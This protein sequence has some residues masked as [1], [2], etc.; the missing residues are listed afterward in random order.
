MTQGRFEEAASEIEPKLEE[1]EAFDQNL[2]RY[3]RALLI[4]GLPERL[5]H[6]IRTFEDRVLA[7]KDAAGLAAAVLRIHGQTDD[8]EKFEIAFVKQRGR[9]QELMRV[10]EQVARMSGKRDAHMK[11]LFDLARVA[12]DNRPRA[13]L[14][15]T[16]LC[17]QYL[18]HDRAESAR[19]LVDAND[20]YGQMTLANL[21]AVKGDRSAVLDCVN[22]W[23]S[24][25]NTAPEAAN[26]IEGLWVS[27]GLPEL[28]DSMRAA[29][30]KW[31]D[32]P[33]VMGSA[34][35]YRF[36]DFERQS[37]GVDQANVNFRI[38]A[39]NHLNVV[40]S[41]MESG[42]FGKAMGLLETSQNFATKEN[43]RRRADLADL[44]VMLSQLHVP[45]SIVVDT[46]EQDWLLSPPGE[47]GKL[48]VVFTGLNG[49]PGIGVQ[50]LDRYLAS[51]GYQVLYLRDFN[52]LTFANGVLSRGPTQADTVSALSQLFAD[53]GA[54][55][56]VFL[57]ASLGA[58]GAVDLGLKLNIKRVLA[59]GYLDRSRSD[60][61][62]RL[63]D[64]RAPVL[65][66][67]EHLN[68][69]GQVPSLQT[70]LAAANRSQP[71]DLF[72]N[73]ANSIDSYYARIF[74]DL[75]Q[76]RLHAVGAGRSHDSLRPVLLNGQL[77]TF[78]G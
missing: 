77:E 46:P 18:A 47:P 39:D 26:M 31:R 44:C 22:R 55:D 30:H 63:G 56:P 64:S 50:A 35:M 4:G 41:E 11:I 75:P 1:A 62:W 2:W 34:L 25:P 43:A 42:N 36:V 24:D 12:G 32:D 9:P 74:K 16:N 6:S 60:D 8:V 69:N 5:I 67:R 61:R 19:D 78:L 72:Y 57:G 66:A 76:V 13:L 38:T 51:L 37:D 54:D 49:R 52:R 23:L 3:A 71:V 28:T 53:S 58:I 29:M 73:P 65:T 15:Y 20:L 59:F 45:R 10:F 48:C 70:H 21:D 33:A 40:V 14:K 17:F 68:A 7:S 27:A